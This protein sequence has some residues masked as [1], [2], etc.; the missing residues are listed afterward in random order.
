M[1]ALYLMCDDAGHW[2][3]VWRASSP[4]RDTFRWRWRYL[5]IIE[6]EDTPSALQA[7]QDR[8]RLRR[9]VSRL[10]SSCPPG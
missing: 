2:P 5:G 6:E 10:S 8:P 9:L 1:P 3:V 7:L 4:P